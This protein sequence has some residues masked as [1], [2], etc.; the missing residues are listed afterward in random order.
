MLCHY[1]IR[2]RVETYLLSLSNQLSHQKCECQKINSPRVVKIWQSKPI[3]FLETVLK[4][5]NIE[6]M[7]LA[8]KIAHDVMQWFQIFNA[9]KNHEILLTNKVNLMCL[10]PGDEQVQD[11]L[12]HNDVKQEFLSMYSTLAAVGQFSAEKF[13]QAELADQKV[14][15]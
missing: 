7:Q 3:S 4:A 2:L 13:L 8:I 5:G 12:L 1:P 10:V 15:S 9:D 11:A 14:Y 6:N